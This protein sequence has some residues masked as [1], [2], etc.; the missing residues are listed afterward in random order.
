MVELIFLGRV[1]VFEA[2]VKAFDPLKIIRIFS[3]NI[4]D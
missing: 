2:S 4:Y 1:E 3:E